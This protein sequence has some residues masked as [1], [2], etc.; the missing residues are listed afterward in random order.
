MDP[1]FAKDN[2]ALLVAA[3]LIGIVAVVLLLQVAARSRFGQL[4]RARKNRS[5]ELAK[6]KSAAARTSRAK[7][8]LDRLRG[9]QRSA[10]P[11]HVSEAEEAYQDA[12]ALQ[13]IAADRVQI[14]NNHVR[15][16]IFEEFPPRA[17]E[18]L[19]RKYLAD[20]VS[21]GRPFTF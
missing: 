16:V 8:R 17:H 6:L 12:L 14:A 1:L 2:W 9:R 4:R 18:K 3:V 15:R 7:K 13:Q 21:D 10:K 20:D 19:R 11:R 5:R